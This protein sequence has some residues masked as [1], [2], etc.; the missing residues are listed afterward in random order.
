MPVL[1]VK[2]VQGIAGL[3]EKRFNNYFDYFHLLT[4]LRIKRNGKI[5]CTTS[6]VE[7]ELIVPF[8]TLEVLF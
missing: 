4:V 8:I 5:K 1:S 2:Y 7:T 6:F 3:L